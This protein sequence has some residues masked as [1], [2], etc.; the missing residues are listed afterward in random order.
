M[1]YKDTQCYKEPVLFF[2][3]GKPL[4]YEKFFLQDI[5][6]Q[7]FHKYDVTIRNSSPIKVC[8]YYF[9]STFLTCNLSY[10]LILYFILD[11]FGLVL[12]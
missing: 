3:D 2:A 7:N 1:L 8:K 11:Y 10:N 12:T 5:A 9:C 6:D 4:M